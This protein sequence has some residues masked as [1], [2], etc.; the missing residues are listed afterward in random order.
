MDRLASFLAFVLIDGIAYGMVLFLISVGLSVTMGLMRFVNL[1]HGAFAAIGGAVAITV[2]SSLGVNFLLALVV[3]FIASALLGLLLEPFLYAPLYGGDEL[4]QVLMTI[5]LIFIVIASL[6]LIFGSTPLPMKL[7]PWLSAS[8]DIGIRVVPA[9]RIFLIVVGALLMVL[10][11]LALDRTEFGARV[12]A[13]VENPQ[14]AQAVGIDTRRLFALTFTLGCGL[15]GLGGALG[16]EMLPIDP[17]YP[18]R[19]LATFL[20]VVS[21][22][23]FGNIKGS[24]WVA[25]MLGIIET[26]GRYLLPAIAAFLTYLVMIALLL[27]RPDG[28]FAK[29]R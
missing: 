14:M 28:L 27:W 7:P 24:A 16:A 29:A 12:R 13:A 10:L 6:N 26:A 3:A 4:D 5:G 20:I 21:I 25:M 1:A 18:F 19:Y 15:A 17:V 8:V 23:G 22:A 9:Y 2:M 11:W